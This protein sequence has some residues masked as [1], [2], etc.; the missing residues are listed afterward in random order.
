MSGEKLADPAWLIIRGG[1]AG[2]VTFLAVHAFHD[3]FSVSASHLGIGDLTILANHTFS[4]VDRR[5]HG[6]DF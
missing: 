4:K 3:R 1:R 6:P 5:S 2:G